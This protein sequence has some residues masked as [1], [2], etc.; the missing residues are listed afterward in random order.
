[1]ILGLLGFFIVVLTGWAIFASSRLDSAERLRR[2]ADED[3]AVLAL[4]RVIEAKGAM[5]A[6]DQD[7]ETWAAELKLAERTG[8]VSSGSGWSYGTRLTEAGRRRLQGR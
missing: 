5:M 3:R 7:I 6:G 1:M 4:L 2:T 8:L